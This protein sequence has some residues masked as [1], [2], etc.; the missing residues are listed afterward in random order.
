[1]R[2][3][4]GHLCGPWLRMGLPQLNFTTGIRRTGVTV[5]VSGLTSFGGA[6]PGQPVRVS[7]MRGVMEDIRPAPFSF[8]CSIAN[9]KE[10]AERAV[11]ELSHAV[12]STL[13]KTG[14]DFS[15]DQ[16][17]LAEGYFLL[18]D[19]VAAVEQTN[20]ALNTLECT[21]S[22]RPL[23]RLGELLQQAKRAPRKR[24][25]VVDVQGRI[26]QMLKIRKSM[27]A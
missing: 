27:L 10:H 14:Q 5:T 12:Q 1:M 15:I 21:Q 8:A 3:T 7:D 20:Q 24:S 25:V 13:A 6:S 22:Q 18:G 11:T 23:A 4:I 16:I 26:Q 17:A 9:T 2:F 19:T